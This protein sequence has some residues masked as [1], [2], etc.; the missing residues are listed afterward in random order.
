LLQ[1]LRRGEQRIIFSDRSLSEMA[2]EARLS[3]KSSRK[4]EEGENFAAEEQFYGPG[5]AD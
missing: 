1:L 2:K 4:E 5:I 3:I